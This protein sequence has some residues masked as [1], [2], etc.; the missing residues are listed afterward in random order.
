MTR[1]YT[2]TRK[3]AVLCKRLVRLSDNVIILNVGSHVN[4]FV[5]NYARLLVNF[6]VR[7]FDKAVFVDSCESC[8][9][10]D[11]TDIRAFRS[12]DRTHS[13]VMAVVYVSNFES[14]TVT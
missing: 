13:A 12:L 10:G 3:L 7:C 6:T 8:E 2:G 4:Y 9:V 11:K 1:I 5:C 14:C